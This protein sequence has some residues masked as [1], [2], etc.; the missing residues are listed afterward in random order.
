MLKEFR[1][2]LMRGS[3][4]DLAVAFVI[5]TAFTA[6]VGALV[7][8]LITPIVAAI[9]GEPDFGGLTFSINNSKFRY[10]D[11]LNATIT[12]VSVAAAVFFFVVKPA[13]RLGM[14]KAPP[15]MRSCPECTTSIPVG[16]K[17]CPQ[18]T[19]PLGAA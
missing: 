3:L 9:F 7:A 4:I 13:G 8:D 12:F 18:C 14:T 15:E 16:A 5:A 2:F 1:D 6:L 11:F 17:R 10:G 19:A